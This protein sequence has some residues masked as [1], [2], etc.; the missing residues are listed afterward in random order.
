[1]LNFNPDFMEW[2]KEASC[3]Y[4]PD[5]DLWHYE[6]SRWLDEQELNAMRIAEAKS[7]CQSCPVKAQCLAEGMKEENTIQVG[8]YV[9]GTIWG[10][11]MF[12]E[13]VA[14]K[15]GKPMKEQAEW[16]LLRQANKHLKR[17]LNE[18]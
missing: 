15:E 14:L 2:T 18:A 6:S 3:A 9:N 7:I 8:N 5:P 1:M 16:K 17:I 13:R 11:M 12:I 10:G 4:H